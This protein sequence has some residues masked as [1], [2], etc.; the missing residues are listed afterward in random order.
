MSSDTLDWNFQR[1]FEK[2]PKDELTDLVQKVDEFLIGYNV[3]LKLAYDL[4]LTLN[5]GAST[6]CDSIERVTWKFLKKDMKWNKAP[7]W[8]MAY[9]LNKAELSI[10]VTSEVEDWKK[11]FSFSDNTM[12]FLNFDK[13]KYFS[14]SFK[15][16]FEERF[17]DKENAIYIFHLSN[18][19]ELKEFLDDA[20]RLYMNEEVVV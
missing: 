16:R 7:F 14:E 15:K 19:E 6:H 4:E 2:F 3:G 1:H 12:R 5:S 11:E 17:K 13:E 8:I 20:I 10:R 9:R 18:I